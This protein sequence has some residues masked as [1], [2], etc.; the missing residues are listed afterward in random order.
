M[1]LTDEQKAQVQEWIAAGLKLSEIQDRLA[2]QFEVH[3]TYMDARLLVDDL[4]LTPKD[5]IEAVPAKPAPAPADATH[6]APPDEDF[7]TGEPAIPDEAM[8]AQPGA[9]GNISVAVD[10]ITRAGAMVSG[11]V[12]FSDGKTAEWYLDQFG[13]FGLVPPEPGYRPSQ[14]DLANFQTLL[15]RELSKLGY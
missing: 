7:G 8:A 2:K 1:Q 14:E 3:L 9:G 15:D 4:K 6:P 10:A 5:H 12:T 13:R 11:K